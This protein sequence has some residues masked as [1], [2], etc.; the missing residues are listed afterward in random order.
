MDCGF[1]ASAAQQAVPKCV[2]SAVGGRP[3]LTLFYHDGS[4]GPIGRTVLGDGTPIEASFTGGLN[5]IDVTAEPGRT[6]HCE[7]ELTDNLRG[8][9]SVIVDCGVVAVPAVVGEAQA[10]ASG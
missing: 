5:L 4:F 9:P 8:R 3:G 6:Y 2:S 7:M 1:A 10:L